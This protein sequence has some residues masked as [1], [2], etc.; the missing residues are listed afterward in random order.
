MLAIP[1]T[2]SHMHDCTLKIPPTPRFGV[3]GRGD[4][5]HVPGSR[6]ARFLC[7]SPPAHRIL[8]ARRNV[9]QQGCRETGRRAGDAGRG[10]DRPR[11]PLRSDRILP[12]LQKRRGEADSRVRNLPRPEIDE[13]KTRDSRPQAG[14]AHDP[15]RPRPGRLAQPLQAG[16]PRPPPR[17]LLRQAAG[18]PRSAGGIRE[19]RDLPHRLHLGAGQRVAAQRRRGKGPRNARRAAR[20]LRRRAHL[21]GTPQPRTGTRAQSDPVPHP[22]GPRIRAFHGGGQR[23]PFP[24]PRRPRCARRDDLHRHRPAGHR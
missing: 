22:A 13:R 6:N 1:R 16:D 8:A 3:G 19:G 23:R 10:D 21:R 9:P 5:V 14:H 7:P 2:P 11:Q 20:H 24:L 12:G 18:G 15:P 17:L 4:S